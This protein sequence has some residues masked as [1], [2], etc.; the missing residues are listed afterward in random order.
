MATKKKSAPKSPAKSARVD[1]AHAATTPMIDKS[2]KTQS[3]ETQ[4]YGE[5]VKMPHGLAESVVKKSVAS[6]N[7]VLADTITLRD[8]YKKHHWQVVGPTFNQLH[9]LFDKHFEEQVE[10]VDL[11]AER[12]Q[13]LGGVSLAMA[14]DIAEET[15]IP[16]PPRGREPATVQLSRLIEAHTMILTYAREHA[17]KASDAGDSGTEDLLVSDIVR[18]NELQVWFLSEHLVA[19]SPI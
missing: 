11:V 8:M 9:L 13:V 7:Q 15:R 14:A 4:R 3:Q 6:L 5:V 12:I 17:E 19:A 2:V 10:L 16:R 18:T 1:A